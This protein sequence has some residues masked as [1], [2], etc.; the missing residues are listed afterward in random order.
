MVDKHLVI[1]KDITSG[2]MNLDCINYLA[3][4]FEKNSEL[5]N[6]ITFIL[7]NDVSN[8]NNQILMQMYNSL[9]G[10]DIF[11]ASFSN[12][13][14]LRYKHLN[15]LQLRKKVEPEKKDLNE[16]LKEEYKNYNLKMHIIED[17]VYENILSIIKEVL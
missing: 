10:F 15:G 2:F 12:D 17:N 7:Q 6:K 1:F 9:I 5:K 3:D 13:T 4:I 11:E 14:L 8:D 16:Y